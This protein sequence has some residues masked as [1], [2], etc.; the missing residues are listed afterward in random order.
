[1]RNTAALASTCPPQTVD[2]V[3]FLHPPLVQPRVRCARAL[4]HI[5]CADVAHVQQSHPKTEK[6]SVR[7]AAPLLVM[8]CGGSG[9][10]KNT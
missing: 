8:L 5:T 10:Q 2:A 9:V 6:Q 4:T 3:M 1:M 7:F